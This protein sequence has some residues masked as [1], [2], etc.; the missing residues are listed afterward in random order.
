MATHFG[1]LL[2]EHSNGFLIEHD[3]KLL[4]NSEKIPFQA[5]WEVLQ[6]YGYKYPRRYKYK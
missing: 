4:Q 3:F 2:L 5:R 6:L 1:L